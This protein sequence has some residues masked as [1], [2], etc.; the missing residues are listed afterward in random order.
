LEALLDGAKDPVI[1]ITKKNQ[2]NA[3]LLIE[4][5]KQTG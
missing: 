2:E 4:S 1:V 5:E 3:A